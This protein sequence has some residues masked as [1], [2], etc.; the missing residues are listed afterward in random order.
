M[1]QLMQLISYIII[2]FSAFSTLLLLIDYEDQE[3]HQ[4]TWT[5]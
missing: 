3:T 1:Y 2:T 4:E 5:L